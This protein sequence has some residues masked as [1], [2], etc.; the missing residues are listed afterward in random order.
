MDLISGKNTL[1]EGGT[2]IFKDGIYRVVGDSLNLGTPNSSDVTTFIADTGAKPLITSSD[3]TPC[4][5]HVHT[6]SIVDGLWFGGTR[7]TSVQVAVTHGDNVKFLR[8]TFFGYYGGIA[9]GG[10]VNNLYQYNRFVNCGGDGLSHDIYI[11]GNSYSSILDNIF[12]AGEGYKIHPW[13]SAANLTAKRNFTATG[14]HHVVLQNTTDI[15]EDNVLWSFLPPL[16]PYGLGTVNIG[17]GQFIHNLFGNKTSGTGKWDHQ[18]NGGEN[19][20]GLTVD[21][22][23]YIGDRY[24]DTTTWP[25][26]SVWVGPYNGPGP[27]VLPAP[28]TNYVHY[29]LEDLPGLIGYSETAVDNAVAALQTSFNQSLQTILN[30]ST[31]EGNFTILRN[32]VVAW[33]NS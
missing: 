23:G 25:G 15:F 9:E 8:C 1:S 26:Y 32:V 31:I 19:D 2:L 14:Y 3:D 18:M 28:G 29:D 7:D 24:L 17:A 12:V 11:S 21:R 4:S 16:Y 33:T 22:C 27:N 5:I 30:D 13:H 20:Q 6:N 10:S